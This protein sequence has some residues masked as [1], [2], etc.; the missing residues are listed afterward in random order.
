[1][2]HGEWS[3]GHSP[4]CPPRFPPLLHTY[5]EPCLTPLSSSLEAFGCCIATWVCCILDTVGPVCRNISS[6]QFSRQI[7][8]RSTAGSYCVGIVTHSR[9]L[10][11]SQRLV[12]PLSRYI[13]PPFVMLP[14]NA[15]T[16]VSKQLHGTK[17]AYKTYWLGRKFGFL[18]ACKLRFCCT[19]INLTTGDT[20]CVSANSVCMP[21]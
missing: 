20:S 8:A 6:K 19:C 1:M 21:A 5:A 7:L 11:L 14:S 18:V 13:L 16:G 17:Y 10:D 2:L 15:P 9:K 4:S 3:T 12:F